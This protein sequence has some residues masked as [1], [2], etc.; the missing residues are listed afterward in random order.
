MMDS[1]FDLAECAEQL[2]CVLSNAGGMV[3]RNCTRGKKMNSCNACVQA[4]KQAL[5]QSRGHV[6]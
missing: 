5:K 1:A 6:K 4:S 3:E 2:A